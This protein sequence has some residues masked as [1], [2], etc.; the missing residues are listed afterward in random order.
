MGRIARSIRLVN[1]PPRKRSYG[2]AFAAKQTELSLARQVAN[3][4]LDFPPALLCTRYSQYT[5]A[6]GT[7]PCTRYPF[8]SFV[9]QPF[10]VWA[11][12]PWAVLAPTLA[13]RDTLFRANVAVSEHSN[14]VATIPA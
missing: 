12:V 1:R 4:M 6:V 5:S 11:G 3:N 2:R 13:R 10:A 8:E 14:W 7:L 9:A